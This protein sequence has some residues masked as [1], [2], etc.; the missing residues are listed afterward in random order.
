M[1]NSLATANQ[2]LHARRI[3]CMICANVFVTFNVV[4]LVKPPF[5]AAL[6][7]GFD[8]L[9]TLLFYFPM[10]NGDNV[11]IF[12]RFFFTTMNTPSSLGAPVCVVSSGTA[13]HG[14]GSH[15]YNSI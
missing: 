15:A 1:R 4:N 9:C 5:A 12:L 8:G 3:R 2:N 11:S 10:R 6:A 13:R 7:L 14:R